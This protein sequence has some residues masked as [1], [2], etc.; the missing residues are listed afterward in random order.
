M[1]MVYSVDTR[2]IVSISGVRPYGRQLSEEELDVKLCEPLPPGQA[3]YNVKDPA[4]IDQIWR[5]VDAGI[6]IR[7]QFDGDTPVG[8]EFE[9]PVPTAVVAE[10]PPVNQELAD[11]YEAIAALYE[12]TEVL[13]ARLAVLEGR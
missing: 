7:P 1:L 2:E 11:A 4:L 6:G 12:E 5:A 8:V 3:T 9:S 13:K 10:D